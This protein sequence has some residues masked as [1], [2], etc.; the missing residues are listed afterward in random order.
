[1]FISRV[2]GLILY[3]HNTAGVL[4]GLRV[5]ADN[6]GESIDTDA[7]PAADILPGDRDIVRAAGPVP[8]VTRRMLFDYAGQPL[9][10]VLHQREDGLTLAPGAAQRAHIAAAMTEPSCWRA[11][12]APATRRPAPAAM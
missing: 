9:V 4:N 5:E 2:E 6:A 8:G 12:S 1:M 10:R 7:R 11:G 3:P